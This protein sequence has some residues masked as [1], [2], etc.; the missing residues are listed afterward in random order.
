MAK[1]MEVE[2]LEILQSDL[3]EIRRSLANIDR[4]T[5]NIFYAAV[6]I[7][8]YVVIRIVLL[9]PECCDFLFCSIG[10]EGKVWDLGGLCFFPLA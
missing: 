5:Q 10:E 9:F 4:P 1:D 8:T 3:K 2:P 7:A 6:L